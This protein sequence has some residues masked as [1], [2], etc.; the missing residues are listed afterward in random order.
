M[1]RAVK[2][3]NAAREQAQKTGAVTVDLH[4]DRPDFRGFQAPDFPVSLEADPTFLEIE[5]AGA[6][7]EKNG[8][9][10]TVLDD[11]FL[12][13]GEIPRTTGY[14]LGI[15]RGIRFDIEKKAWEQDTLIK[16]ERFLMC[17]LK[18]SSSHLSWR[19]IC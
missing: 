16:D 5:D 17:K 19:L 18:G 14:E 7:V 12:I 11:M 6:T 2:S 13:S 3:I 10:H 8:F 15:R 1:L 4:P 9:T